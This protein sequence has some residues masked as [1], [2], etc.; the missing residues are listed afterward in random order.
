MTP[1]ATP[2]VSPAKPTPS[3]PKSFLTK[4]T[5]SKAPPGM[6]WKPKDANSDETLMPGGL[7]SSGTEDAPLIIDALHEFSD[8]QKSQN[9]AAPDIGVTDAAP[10]KISAEPFPNT[11]ELPLLLA[12]AMASVNPV[13]PAPAQEIVEGENIG[14]TKAVK[15]V[16][17]QTLEKSFLVAAQSTYSRLDAEIG[18]PNVQE[19]LET[20]IPVR[21]YLPPTAAGNLARCL[22]YAL[23]LVL[24]K[25]DVLAW[26]QLLA[27]PKCLLN[28]IGISTDAKQPVSFAHLV[29]KRC[30]LFLAGQFHIIWNE[31][32][33]Q[34]QPNLV[35]KWKSDWIKLTKTK[36]EA[37]NLSSAFKALESNSC[38]KNDDE[39]FEKLKLLHPAVAEFIGDK[40]YFTKNPKSNFS[41]DFNVDAIFKMFP[42][43]TSA[44]PD[45]LEVQHLLDLLRLNPPGNPND[46]RDVIKK[47]MNLLI[48]GGAPIDL[49]PYLASAKLIPLSKPNDK[50]GVRPI[51]IGLVWRRATGKILMKHVSEAASKYLS[52]EQFGVGVAGGAEKV[53]HAL[54]FARLLNIKNPDFAILQLDF[55]NAF[56]RISRKFFLEAVKK[57]FPELLPFV[58]YCYCFKP[59]LFVNGKRV[60]IDSE[61][62]SQQ[63]DPLGPFLF[64]LVMNILVKEISKKYGAKIL[65]LWYLDD[66]TIAGRPET[67]HE[68]YN[69]FEVEGPKLG[70]FVNV[71]KSKIYWPSGS[72]QGQ[73]LFPAEL[74]RE[75][76][77]LLV[78]GSPIGS[79][80]FISRAFSSKLIKID[81]TIQK[82]PKLDDAQVA[83]TLVQNCLGLSSVNYFTRTTPVADTKQLCIGFDELMVAAVTK[84]LGAPITTIQKN[85]LHLP[86]KSGGLGIKSA[87]KHSISAYTSSFN[88]CTSFLSDLFRGS[89]DEYQMLFN[90]I[91][92]N[93]KN[94][95]YAQIGNEEDHL[96]KSKSQKVISETI[97]N[98]NFESILSK[99][100]KDTKARLRSCCG[101]QAS[102]VFKAPLSKN[103]GFRLNNPDFC[104]WLLTRLG[105]KNINNPQET[106]RCGSI[107][108]DGGTG[109]HCQICKS[110]DFGPV[111]RHNDVRDVLHHYAQKAIY[112]ARKEV[113]ITTD[114][115][116]TPGDLYFKVGPAGKPIAYDITVV[117]PLSTRV[118]DGACNRDGY[119]M[120]EAERR[121]IMK[122]K[123]L[124]EKHSTSFVPIAFEAFGRFADSTNNLISWLATG[125]SNRTGASRS[126]IIT[127]IGRKISFSLIR[128]YSGAIQSRCRS[129]LVE[130]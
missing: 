69:F 129:S 97:D 114:T 125:V 122:Y 56:N 80:D 17:Q 54:R 100:T 24:E 74:S 110:G 28:P 39:T 37:G 118:I 63:G 108:A 38:I 127:E 62:G 126:S 51:A 47:F 48:N 104:I 34:F 53:I 10:T 81:E 75:Q 128:S 120:I 30:S 16:R 67:L 33:D 102:Y 87:L 101:P 42:K 40:S 70:L 4:G 31:V 92:E 58:S 61:N 41:I 73:E 49:A 36:V 9:S 22:I 32:I 59:K 99:S 6:S 23:E 103:R 86:I 98:K 3:P 57:D 1:A 107:M 35:K 77:G 91:F 116:K 7:A 106:C 45:G 79:D 11:Q 130:S 94:V 18:I 72:M 21:S 29:N 43:G 90:E 19:I 50:S 123:D 95:L 14:G 124:C 64:A 13:A 111:A 60:I 78:L 44:G 5:P 27:L 12:E 82:L 15:S 26:T 96:H 55:S 52:P 93:N 68:I 84:I 83:F 117:H 20:Y 65:N 113:P 88:A 112:Y 46:P 115:K 66:G 119:A 85:Q 76:E 2:A 71:V 89:I 109:Y 121:K 25:N 8:P 105:S